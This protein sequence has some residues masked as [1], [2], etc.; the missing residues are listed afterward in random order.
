MASPRENSAMRC[1]GMPSL[2]KLFIAVGNMRAA[3]LS[4]SSFKE[5]PTVDGLKFCS[6]RL[7]PPKKNPMPTM[8]ILLEM[9]A[10]MREVCTICI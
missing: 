5:L 10:P 6:D 4:A 2:L 3:M 9:T 1:G 7:M 8:S